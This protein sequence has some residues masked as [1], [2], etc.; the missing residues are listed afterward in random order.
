MMHMTRDC[1]RQHCK[2]IVIGSHDLWTN[3]QQWG[4][5]T[6]Q[7]KVS[8]MNNLLKTLRVDGYHNTCAKIADG[9]YNLAFGSVSICA[10]AF[11]CLYTM[12]VE[13]LSHAAIS[14]DCRS[15]VKPHSGAKKHKDL[16]AGEITHFAGQLFE[17][18]SSLRYTLE[19]SLLLTSH[20]SFVGVCLGV[21]LPF[22]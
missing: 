19:H 10:S 11:A 4:L 7:D 13:M 14:Q 12:S 16:S 5:K 15:Y 21:C 3:W 17:V 9:Y 20:S 18:V 8:E 2:L 6:D 1:C 22:S